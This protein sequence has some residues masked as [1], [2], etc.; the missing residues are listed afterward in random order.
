MF[1][2]V[3]F[4]RV[5]FLESRGGARDHRI[6]PSYTTGL[7]L[8]RELINPTPNVTPETAISLTILN[9]KPS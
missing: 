5:E 7:N 2:A 3:S 4:S 6:A 8:L 9:P 1:R